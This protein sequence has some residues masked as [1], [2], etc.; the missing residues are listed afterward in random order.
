[1]IDQ[2]GKHYIPMVALAGGEPTLSPD[3]EPVLDRCRKYGIHTTIATHG[4]LLTPE[5]CRRLA[6]L[7][8]GM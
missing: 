2:F 1:L 3:L 7:A 4:G 8:C 5:R 6:D